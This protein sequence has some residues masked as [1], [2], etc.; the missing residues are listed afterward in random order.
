MKFRQTSA[1]I[2]ASGQSTRMGRNKLF[3]KYQ[4]QTF[5][6]RIL[7]LAKKAGFFET[8]LVITPED[9]AG[10]F[11]PEDIHVVYNRQSDLGQSAAVRLGTREATGDGYLYLPVDQPLLTLEILEAIIQ[12]G[13]HDN[14][15]FPL[16]AG[17]PQSP[18][19]F[20]ADFYEEL[21]QVSGS[22]G[23]REV[24]NN[25]KDA[26]V[27]VAVSEEYLEDIDT[28]ADYENLLQKVF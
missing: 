24:R 28:P 11:L 22:S 9:A 27:Q 12:R 15:V 6:E 21:L 20:G 18:V 17:E 16:K 13:T 25:H 19:Y 7:N 5:L 4:G 26:W 2:M 10:C 8:I 14:I 1:I 23:G 3:L